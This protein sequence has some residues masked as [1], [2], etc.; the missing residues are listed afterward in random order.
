MRTRIFYLL[1]LALAIAAQVAAQDNIH[2][3]AFW[4]DANGRPLRLQS[5]FKV[6]GSPYYNDEYCE[7][8]VFLSNGKKY[9]NVKVKVN[10]VDNDIVFMNDKKEEMIVTSSVSKVHFYACER[11]SNKPV[12]IAALAPVMN[13]KGTTLYEILVD[14]SAKLLKKVSANYLDTKGYNEAGVTRTY[15][16]TE[17]LYALLP[18]DAVPVKVQKSKNGV[19]ELFTKNQQMVTAFIEK[20][21]LRCKSDEDIAEIFQYYNSIQQ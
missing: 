15:T 6:E 9:Q 2:N 21:K 5:E 11:R 7:A 18:G 13:Q 20:N 14:G 8:D 12:T 19:I 10:L 16:I 1:L 4:N 17:T 3:N